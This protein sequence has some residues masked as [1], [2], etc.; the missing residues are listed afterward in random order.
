M[1]SVMG[2]RWEPAFAYLFMQ[3][4]ASALFSL[5][6]N[7]N[8]VYQVMTVKL[9]PLEL[10]LVGSALEATVLIFEVPTGLVA[11]GFSRR[12]SVLVGLGLTGVSF[13]IQ[14]SLP[15]FAWIV[16][17]QVVWGI[18][19][20]FTSGATTAWVV[21]EVG[22]AAAEPLFLRET[23][24]SSL[25]AMAAVPLAVLLGSFNLAWPII[26]SGVA[27]LLLTLLLAAKMT[28]TGF[29]PT[30]SGSVSLGHRLAQSLGE[31]IRLVSRH[32]DLRLLFGV[33]VLT[34][35]ASEGFD[36]LMTPH[37]IRDIGFPVV[38]GLAPVVW[39]AGINLLGL[40]LSAA[41]ARWLE[42]RL[43]RA[44]THHP[45]AALASLTALTAAGSLAFGLAGN[46]GLALAGTLG[47][48]VCRALSVPLVLIWLNRSIPSDLRATVLSM[49]GQMDAVGQVAGGPLIGW[50][51]SS[52]S[53]AA[54]LMASAGVLL[55]ATG[56]YLRPRPQMEVPVEA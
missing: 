21:D 12:L 14:G 36:R 9:S 2:R 55:P 5:A 18:G 37:W 26:L 45:A 30:R 54:A 49:E 28:E 32:P 40:G 52:V 48:R 19:Y 41:G 20:T 8:L 16:I 22:A 33:S 4:S 15:S 25:A 6:F 31:S 44:G 24:L 29:S 3:A 17:S 11:D 43:D 35:A 53:I 10:V 38:G 42:R 50:V 46:F 27:F 13:L 1:P 39:L 23:R 56:L 34:G 7:V 51:G 47:V